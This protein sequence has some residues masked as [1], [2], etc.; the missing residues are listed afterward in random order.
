MLITVIRRTL[1]SK[2]LNPTRCLFLAL[3]KS[4]SQ[5]ELRALFYKFFQPRK[6]TKL[7]CFQYIIFKALTSSQQMGKREWRLVYRFLFFPFFFS[8]VICSH[9][10]I[11]K[12]TK[13]CLICFKSIFFLLRAYFMRGFCSP[14]Q[15]ECRSFLLR[16]VGLE[17]VTQPHPTIRQ[18]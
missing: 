16:C 13:F 14:T 10:K 6:L 17:S 15:K 12:Q 3:V 11:Q 8:F 7:C 18:L 9:T 2:W 1:K 4:D 5:K